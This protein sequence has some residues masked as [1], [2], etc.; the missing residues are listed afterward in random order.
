[1]SKLIA[2]KELAYFTKQSGSLTHEFFSN[3]DLQAGTKAHQYI[4]A[5]YNSKSQSE[6]YIKHDIN[7]LGSDYTLHGFI[8]GVLNI[9]DEIIIEELK[10]TTQELDT[11]TTNYHLEHQAQLKVYGYL[12]A[13]NNNIP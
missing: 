8:D 12:Y 6:V 3:H 1:M 2:I 4:Q 9:N 13:L 10:S 5:K 7:Y 11:I